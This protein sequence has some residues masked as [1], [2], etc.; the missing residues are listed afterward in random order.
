MARIISLVNQKGGVGK[1]TTAVNVAGFLAEMGKL[2]LLIDVDPQ[3]NASSGLGLEEREGMRG[4]YEVLAGEASIGEVIHDGPVENLKAIP[5]TQALAG[6]AVE[7]VGVEEREFR[8]RKALLEIRNDFD[9]IILD[10]PPSLGL[11]T[12]N[13]LTAA[14]EVLIPVQAEYYALEGLGQLLNTI[15]LVKE[16]L[17]PDLRIL[18]AIV[19]MFEKR[20]KL[21]QQVY[22]DMQ[23]HFPFK[24]FNTLI[25]RTVKLAEAPSFGKI[26]VQYDRWSKG[27]RAY[28]R[29]TEELIK[30]EDNL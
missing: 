16:N 19:T 21:A 17:N 5:A 3:A 27:A 14:D 6:A 29:L 20:H 8:L 30:T 10:N 18:G 22:K 25:P 12:V 11:I 26:M 15:N 2:V 13:S 7:L 1:T 9:Y 23:M 4:V 28:Q 24:V